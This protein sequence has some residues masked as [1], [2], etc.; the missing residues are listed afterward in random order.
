MQRYLIKHILLN[1]IEHMLC[2][3]PTNE[4][5]MPKCMLNVL[6][7]VEHAVHVQLHALLEN[8]WGSLDEQEGEALLLGP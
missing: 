3:Y 6:H 7:G 1:I 8:T 5:A 4:Y 2:S